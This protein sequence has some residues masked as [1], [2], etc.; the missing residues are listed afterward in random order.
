[1][2]LKHVFSLLLIGGSLLTP[3]HAEEPLVNSTIS[4]APA[5]VA[6]LPG[7]PAPKVAAPLICPPVRGSL[8]RAS[9]NAT[10]PVLISDNES[11]H[12]AITSISLIA[13]PTQQPRKIQK[14]DLIQ[15]VISESSSAS[16][17]STADSKKTQDFDIALQQFLELNRFGGNVGLGN[18]SSPGKLPEVKFKFNNDT[19][20]N[21]DAARNDQFSGRIEAEVM[22]VKPNGTLVVEATKHIRT[23][24]EEQ[25]FRLTGICRAAD[26]TADNTVLSTQL[27]DL[28]LAKDT[29]GDVHNGTKRGWMNRVFDTLSPF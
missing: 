8:F 29:K 12:S 24:K 5:A 3:A 23:D 7:V 27:A 4:E 6:V 21:A 22:D 13:V 28:K 15:V 17:T 1:M 19:K 10:P 9:L 14:H 25:T 11:P 2:N 26:I 20:A 16:S 18:V